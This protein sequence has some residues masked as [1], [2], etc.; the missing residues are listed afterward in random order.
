MYDCVWTQCE[1][2][3]LF[4]VL[5]M[6]FV[7]ALRTV[8]GTFGMAFRATFRM[9]RTAFWTAFRT[10]IRRA[11]GTIFRRTF[12]VWAGVYGGVQSLFYQTRQRVASNYISASILVVFGAAFY[13][14]SEYEPT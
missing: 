1:V 5:E 10:T 12:G 8:F 4:E 7:R 11:F 14:V 3:M 2:G 13:P 6:V 9:F